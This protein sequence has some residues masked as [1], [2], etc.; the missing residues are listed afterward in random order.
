MPEGFAKKKELQERINRKSG[1]IE[2]DGNN[3]GK[4]GKLCYLAELHPSARI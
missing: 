4:K 2:M 3:F 1:T